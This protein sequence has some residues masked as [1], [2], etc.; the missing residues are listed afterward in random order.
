MKRLLAIILTFG[1][2]SLAISAMSPRSEGKALPQKAAQAAGCVPLKVDST[3][4]IDLSGP[5]P[6][7]PDTLQGRSGPHII[8][9]KQRFPGLSNFAEIT[10]QL[11]RGGRPSK[12]GLDCLQRM[13]I[14]IVISTE[15]IIKNLRKETEK[16]GMQYVAMGWWCWFPDDK[17]FAEF[18]QLLRDNPDKKVYVY[19]HIGADRTSMMIAAYRMAEQNWSPDEAKTEMKIFGFNFIHRRLCTGLSSYVDDFPSHWEKSEAFEKLRTTPPPTATP[20]LSQQQ[21]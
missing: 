19:C 8:P 13:G 7:D 2:F 10:P 5:V 20:K 12:E 1:T 21:P 11:Y 6:P 4:S 3:R 9:P 16:R 14:N 17:L 18:L 15:G